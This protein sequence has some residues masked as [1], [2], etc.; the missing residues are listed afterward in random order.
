MN[1]SGTILPA[2]AALKASGD[3]TIRPGQSKTINLYTTPDPDGR[4]I[5]GIFFKVLTGSGIFYGTTLPGGGVFPWG[6]VKAP[7]ATGTN[8][9]LTNEAGMHTVPT[10]VLHWDNTHP[11]GPLTVEWEIHWCQ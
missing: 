2:V 5:K 3:F 10:S 11:A 6:D 4:P 1:Y 9:G 7:L 8:Y